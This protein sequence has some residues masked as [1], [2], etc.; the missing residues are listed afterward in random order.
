MVKLKI[1]PTLLEEKLECVIDALK[2]LYVSFHNCESLYLCSFRGT[3][4]ES[5]IASD[6][7]CPILPIPSQCCIVQLNFRDECT[8]AFSYLFQIHRARSVPWKTLYCGNEIWIYLDS[9]KNKISSTD[10]TA[11]CSPCQ[12]LLTHDVIQEIMEHNKLGT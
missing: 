7:K 8:P 9:C 2:L 5:E 6:S 4:V 3:D 1:P 10:L 12:E 11:A